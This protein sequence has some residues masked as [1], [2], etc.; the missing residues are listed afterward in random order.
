MELEVI[1]G[2]EIH[3]QMNTKTKFFCGCDN[4][5]FGKTP[6]TN[7]CPICM[8]YPGQL[9]VPNAAVIQKAI[10]AGLAL[11]CTIN[12]FSKFDRKQYFYPDS[13]KG[14][15]ITQYDKPITEH[16]KVTITVD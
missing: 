14:F 12:T 3:A 8:G 5:S 11:E 9:P 6:N 16:G 2:L 1:I 15:H 10:A 4:D 7:V 13:P